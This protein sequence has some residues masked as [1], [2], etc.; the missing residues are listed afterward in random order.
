MRF[1]SRVRTVADSQAAADTWFR[2]A[3]RVAEPAAI[4]QPGPLHAANQAPTFSAPALQIYRVSTLADGSLG[5][6]ASLGPIA[7]SPD[8]TRIAFVSFATNFASDDTNGQYDVFIKNLVTGEIT[9]VS[10]TAGGAPGNGYSGNALN[11]PVFSPDGTK[12]MFNTSAENLG[13]EIVGGGLRGQVVIK[14]LVTGAVTRASQLPDGT[15]AN[16][17]STPL[18][19]STD[20]TKVLFYSAASNLSAGDTNGQ[21]DLF[22]KD[23]TN[24]TLIRVS[25]GANGELGNNNASPPSAEFSP[26]GT[27]VIFVSQ[28]SNLV[29]G[30]TNNDCDIFLRNLVSGELTIVSRNASGT[31]GN[32]TSL[33]CHFSPD[34]TKVLFTSGADNLVAGDTNGDQDIFMKD[35]ATGAVMRV[36]SG[37]N[38]EQYFFDAREARF[39]PDGTKVVFIAHGSQYPGDTN[40]QYDVFVK[41][42][43]TGAVTWVTSLGEGPAVPNLSSIHPVFL[44]NGT[45]ALQ[46]PSYRLNGG[47]DTSGN[48]DIFLASPVTKY[49]ENGVPLQILSSVNIGDADS[50]NYAGGT[51]TIAITAGAELSDRLVFTPNSLGPGF[52]LELVGSDVRFRSASVG[53]LTATNTGYTIVL[54]AAA[55]D[56]AVQQMVRAASFY[57]LSENP[58]GAARTVTFSLVDGGGTAGGGHDTAS[59][60]RSIQVLP[61]D[62]PTITKADLFVTFIATLAGNVVADNGYGADTDV[63]SA[64]NVVAVNGAATVG[65]QIALASGALLTVNANGDFAYNRNGAFANGIGA[66]DSFTYRPQLGNTVTV[67]IQI[68]GA[69]QA[70]IMGTSAPEELHSSVAVEELVGLGGNDVYYLDHVSDVAREAIGGGFDTVYA[71]AGNTLAPGS[72]IE[73]LA[74]ADAAGTF[75]MTLTGNEFAQTLVGNAGANILDGRGG[76]DTMV[77]GAGNDWFFVDDTA[78]KVLEAIGEG[79][80]RVFAGVSYTLT[81]GAEVEMLTTDFN[82]G[83]AAINLTGNAGVQAIYGNAGANQLA[84]GGGADSLAGFQG[85][86]WYFITDGRESVFEA[87]G[88][89]SDRVFASVSYVLTGG[90][91]VEILSTTFHAG[92]GAIDL[93]GNELA[94]VIIGNDGINTLNGGGGNDT[95]VGRAG[96]DILV[97]GA[98]ADLTDGGTGNDWF[99]VD[100][101]SD[102]VLEAAGEGSDRVFAGVSY[103]LGAGA[104]VEMLT[105]DFN[106]GTAAINLTGNAGVQAIYGNAGANQLAGGGGADTLVGFQGDD[107]YFITDGHESVFETAA[108]G[109]DRVFASVSYTLTAGAEVEIMSTNLHTGTGAI[110]LTGNELANTIYGNDGANILDGKGGSDTLIGRAGNDLFA[111]TTTL[112]GGNVDT[113]LDFVAGSDKLQL[114]HAVFTGLGLGGLGPNAFVVG[115]QAGDGDDRIIYNQATGQL[116]FDADG[117]GAGAAVQFATLSGAPVISASDFQVI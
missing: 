18:A 116:F 105:T 67:T 107:W 108:Q 28:A 93:T 85:D 11:A 80:D 68:A 38:G 15:V 1:Q 76:A 78:D 41:D 69:T 31:L 22:V 23:L 61:V 115:T 58:S 64:P 87:A 51:L 63:D 84:G 7:V 74:A 110:D 25:S 29:A 79:S 97:G 2:P 54:K 45:I 104:E 101:A 8:G 19:W 98:G 75:A 117:N 14:D 83:T 46:G 48:N 30:D 49:V 27:K 103:A 40:G 3:G 5:N 112:G 100:N 17:D 37:P 109:N 72:E 86:D 91:E 56:E 71:A 106:G 92:T 44:D 42:L 47:A 55:D 77:G 88:E 21:L 111:F 12:L 62:D 10:R 96:N 36:S 60:T 102:V 73:V 4:A 99:F 20:G 43:A 95:L 66:F 39:S 89:G 34:G 59:F 53:T 24:G 57:N 26:D 35:L 32:G 13:A 70:T 33:D 9:L 52:G 50:A 82:A 114:D 94:N 81:A 6:G 113:I 65:T 90:A 16:F